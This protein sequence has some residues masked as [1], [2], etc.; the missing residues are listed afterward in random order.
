MNRVGVAQRRESIP[1][2]EGIQE[3]A[4]A[5][6]ERPRPTAELRQK[7]R[8]WHDQIPLGDKGFR[9]RRRLKRAH[10]ELPKERTR[11]ETLPDCS[12]VRWSSKQPQQAFDSGELN[13]YAAKV[14]KQNVGRGHVWLCIRLTSGFSRGGSSLRPPSAA[15]RLRPHWCT[16][17]QPFVENC[18]PA[19]TCEPRKL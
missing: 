5:R 8:G 7:R 10:L 9:K 19:T 3:F 16:Q 13:E 15:N 6:E 14:E 17:S 1:G 18:L 2:A 11:H 12:L 4:S